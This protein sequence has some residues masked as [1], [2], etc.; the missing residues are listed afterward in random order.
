MIALAVRDVEKKHAE[1]LET[2]KRLVNEAF[3][4]LYK[5][6]QKPSGDMMGLVVNTL[7]GLKRVEVIRV[8]KTSSKKIPDG[9]EGI[10]VSQ[11]G[12][13]YFCRASVEKGVLGTQYVV[14]K[15][16]GL[17]GKSVDGQG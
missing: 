13:S 16:K 5:Q 7:P 10:Q 6:P 14:G 12:N 4:V 9:L 15:M 1:L 3:A 17:K 11:D 2:G 8:D